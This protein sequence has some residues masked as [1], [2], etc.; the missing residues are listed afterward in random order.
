[1]R[2]FDKGTIGRELERARREGWERCC[3]E[4][5]RGEGLPKGLLLAIASHETDMNDTVGDNGHG[6]G[7]FQIDDRSH[8]S[9][10]A[11]Q[12]AARAGGKPPVPEAARYAARILR[13]NRA[14]GE[15][16]GVRKSDL[17]KFSVSAYNAG[18]GGALKGYEAGDSDL[19]TT[20]GDYSR[21][22]LG[23]HALF[24]ELLADSPPPS[25]LRLGSRNGRVVELK[26]KLAAWYERNA[27]GE[28]KSFRVR[29]GPRFGAAL[30]RAVRDFQR[31]AGLVVDGE[32]GPKTLG[33]LDRR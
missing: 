7:L 21:S 19:R 22:V 13:D 30:D 15:R 10:L 2:H 20:G 29:P 27:P 32:A 6:R 8:R 26:E 11:S 25:V 17:M 3:L 12:G 24:R 5:E 4:A 1:M 33:A 9:F 28:W 16:K 31:R 14:F 23:R 18:A